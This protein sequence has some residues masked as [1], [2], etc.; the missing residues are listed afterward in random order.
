MALDIKWFKG[1]NGWNI[2][3]GDAYLQWY[4]SFIMKSIMTKACLMVGDNEWSDLKL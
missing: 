2:I 3:K 4:K 1:L